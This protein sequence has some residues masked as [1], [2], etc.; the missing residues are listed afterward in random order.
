[1]VM[2]QMQYICVFLLLFLTACVPPM[3]NQRG[4]MGVSAKRFKDVE[5]GVTTRDDIKARFGTP[6]ITNNFGNEAWYYIGQRKEAVAFL[7]PEI[8]KQHVTRIVF[9]NS[10]IVE[11]IE[12]YNAED[13]QSVTLAE[14]TTPTEGQKLGFVEQI[15]GNVGRFNAGDRGLGARSPASGGQW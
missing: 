1:M 6:S 2:R 12:H 9:D 13:A 4:H 3:V 15:L 5:V 8:T 7:N 14:E 10:G 11:K